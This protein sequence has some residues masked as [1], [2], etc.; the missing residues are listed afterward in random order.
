MEVNSNNIQLFSHMTLG[1]YKRAHWNPGVG[2]WQLDNFE[3]PTYK[4]DALSF[5]HADRADVEKGAVEVAEYI[6]YRYC[7]GWNEFA[8]WN[9]CK[10]ADRCQST[11][12][13]RYSAVTDSFQVEIVEGLTDSFG[14]V[15]ER[16]CRWGTTGQ[17]VECFLYDLGVKEGYVSI[18]CC[19]FGGSG[20][21]VYTPEAAPFISFTDTETYADVST[22]FAVWPKVWP[23]SSTG[24]VWPSTTAAG[25]GEAS[26]TIIR[27][28]RAAENA[29]FSPYNDDGNTNSKGIA[30]HGVTKRSD[31]TV[32]EY[33]ARIVAAIV[34]LNG[35]PL[36]VNNSADNYGLG[37]SGAGPEGWFDGS[38]NGRDL[39]TYNCV[40]TI[41]ATLVEACWVST[42][43]AVSDD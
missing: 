21:N 32:A 34:R 1:G 35:G 39:Q 40:G 10:E 17:T 20:V 9:G 13:A 2:L 42:N 14:G 12:N 16:L 24:L 22:K 38:V 19:P 15:Q 30:Y 18:V 4:V 27:A 33:E 26:K 36:T 6:R 25:T 11:H 43:G 28:V 31:E 37:D 7:R 23:A 29:R 5:S 3:Y 8:A 41:D